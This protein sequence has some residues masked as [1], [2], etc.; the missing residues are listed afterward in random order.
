MKRRVKDSIQERKTKEMRSNIVISL[1]SL[2]VEL[3]LAEAASEQN[4]EEICKCFLALS[5]ET[6]CFVC[7]I[8]NTTFEEI[9][10]SIMVNP[11]E[12]HKAN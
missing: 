7:N 2:A 6:V 4:I 5:V 10:K 11:L 3:Y 8:P 12:L 9:S 1:Y